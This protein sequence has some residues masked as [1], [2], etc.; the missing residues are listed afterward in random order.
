LNAGVW[1]RR[2]RL[3]IVSLLF[4]SHL[5]RGQAE[6]PIIPPSRFSRPALKNGA[7]IRIGD[8]GTVIAAAEDAKEAAWFQPKR[9]VIVDTHKQPGFNVVET[10]RRIKDRLPVLRASLPPSVELTIVGDRTQTIRASVRDVQVT[11]LIT[12]GLALLWQ[13]FRLRRVLGIE[14]TRWRGKGE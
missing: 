13:I 3:L 10:I 9:T 5:G 4:G 7:P 14:L 1:F 8:L 11:L 6:T 12:V 2:G